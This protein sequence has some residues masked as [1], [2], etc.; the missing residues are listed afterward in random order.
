MPCYKESTR[1]PDFLQE[2]CKT[3]EASQLP[4]KILTV[5]DGSG[6]E[7]A[8]LMFSLVQ[9]LQEKFNLLLDALIL[10]QNQGKGGAIYSGWNE[11]DPQMYKWIAFVDADGAISPE[12]TLNFLSQTKSGNKEQRTCLWS[13]RVTGEGKEVNRTK[14]RQA[15]GNIFRSIVKFTFNLPVRDTQCGLKCLPTKA[16]QKIQNKLMEKRFVFDI[17]LAAHLT[18]QGY[19]LK[20]IPVN[21]HESPGSTINIKSAFKMLFSLFVIR[22]RLLIRKS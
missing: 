17:E 2:L 19:K 6:P 12:E 9:R 10:E 5:D 15:L 11:A 3:A 4:I 21:W 20:E 18:R 16:Y 7:E 13:V 8:E 14:V 22:W 1:L